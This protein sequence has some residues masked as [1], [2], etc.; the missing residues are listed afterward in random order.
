[1]IRPLVRRWHGRGLKAIVYLDDGI[2][3]VVE[4]SQT[5][6]ESTWVQYELQCAGFVVNVEKLAWDPNKDM[7][8][9]GFII[10]LAKGE[11]TVLEHKLVK[12]KSQLQ[13]ALRSQ[14]MPARILASLIGRIISMSLALGLVTR[15]MTCS[16]Y[17]TLNSKAA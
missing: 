15:L 16:L 1:M 4:K 14:I 9:L 6:K 8:W 12:L 10:D 5:L 11:F 2:I 7:E 3:T 13:E 17:A